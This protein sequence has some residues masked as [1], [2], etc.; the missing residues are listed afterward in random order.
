MHSLYEKVVA[1]VPKL[2][3]VNLKIR[4]GHFDGSGFIPDLCNGV[5]IDEIYAILLTVHDNDL[6]FGAYR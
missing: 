3:D 1:N 6:T 4:F 2:I 5:R